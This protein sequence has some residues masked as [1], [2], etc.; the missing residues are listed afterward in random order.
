MTVFISGH[1]DITLEEF[2]AHYAPILDSYVQAGCD[3]IVGDF[4]G[5]DTIA[6]GYLA[7]EGCK[8]TVYHMLEK[9]R[10]N[11]INFPTVGGFKNDIERDE[12][13]TKASHCDLAWVRPGREASG[14]AK[15]LQRR[16]LWTEK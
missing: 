13:M 2:K 7:F 16:K 15:N 4:K 1:G 9:A 12:A 14:T 5:T 11:F 8:V 3:F 6:Q 10:F